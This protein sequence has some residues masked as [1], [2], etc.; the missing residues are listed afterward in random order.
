MRALLIALVFVGCERSNTQTTRTVFFRG[1]PVATVVETTASAREIKRVTRLNDETITLTASLDVDGF[2]IAATSDRPGVRHMELKDGAVV[3]AFGHRIPVAG[4]VLLVELVHRVRATGK[5]AATLVDLSSAEILAVTVERRGPEVVVTDAAGRVV[6]RALPEGS[7]VGPGVFAEGDTAP[8]LPA[9]PVEIE[10]PG[11]RSVKG[12]VLAGA[13]DHVKKPT[14]T[15]TA[16]DLAA[17]IFLESDDPRVKSFAACLG[18]PLPDAL[19]IAERVRPLVDA[20][21]RDQPPSALGM[22][23]AGGDCD[24]AAALVV[25]AL[26]SCG[27]PARALV[28]YKL[29]AV[30][31]ADARLVPHAVAEV[32]SDGLWTKVDATVPA[33]GSLDDVFLPVAEGL[34][35]SLTMGRVLGVIGASDVLTAPGPR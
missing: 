10:L 14:T 3:D 4:R 31:S 7:R 16:A 8:L 28:G 5:N 35:G 6:V 19:A 12:A 33:I 21:K 27:H 30:G 32:Y 11:R 29:T 1:E 17:A 22:L 18:S 25:A 15:T 23:A 26:R 9:A 20:K 24:G 13:A 2:A 34:G